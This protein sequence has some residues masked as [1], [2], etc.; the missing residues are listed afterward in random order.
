MRLITAPV[1]LLS[2]RPSGRAASSQSITA[3]DSCRIFPSAG[4]YCHEMTIFN[5][6]AQI[7]VTTGHRSRGNW[8]TA[9]PS[10]EASKLTFSTCT[11][12]HASSK[13]VSRSKR[14]G[15]PLWDQI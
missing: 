11:P 9:Q 4:D 14:I 12:Q 7:M 13:R 5:G 6:S 3:K 8:G 10:W 15:R 1:G 2:A